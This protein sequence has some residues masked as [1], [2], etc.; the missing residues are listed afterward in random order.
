MHVYVDAVIS[1]GAEGMIL[2]IAFVI[3]EGDMIDALFR[4]SSMVPR[5]IQIH[6]IRTTIITRAKNHMNFRFESLKGV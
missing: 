4:F 1:I 5:R 3:V 2:L 6:I